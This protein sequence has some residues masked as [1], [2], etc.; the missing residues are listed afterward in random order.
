MSARLI[1]RVLNH[2]KAR[3]MPRL[4]LITLAWILPE[5]GEG[6]SDDE[7]IATA[8]NLHVRN[9]QRAIRLLVERGEL[10]VERGGG[11]GRRSFYRI[12]IKAP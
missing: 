5:S 2:S 6:Y 8:A 12:Q 1:A 9:I 3:G 7:E 10:E 4:V 11:R